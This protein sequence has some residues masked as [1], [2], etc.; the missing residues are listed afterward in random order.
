MSMY[1]TQIVTFEP[2]YA[3]DTARRSN[4][5]FTCDHAIGSFFVGLTDLYSHEAGL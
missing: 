5:Y 4:L 1:Q 3:V 2:T